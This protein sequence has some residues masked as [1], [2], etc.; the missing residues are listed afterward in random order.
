MNDNTIQSR[1]KELYPSQANQIGNYF[2]FAKLESYYSFLKDFNEVGGFFSKSDS[3]N[4]LD[5]HIIES[6]MHIYKIQQIFPVSHET[7]LADI[8]TGPG[9]PGYIFY[10]LKNPPQITLVDSQ[11]R[12]LGLLEKFHKETS[13]SKEVKFVYGRVEDIKEKFDLV[14]MRSTIKYPWSAEMIYGLLR[15]HSSFIPFLAKRNYDSNFEQMLLN[16]LG[17]N[18]EKEVDI[19]ELEFLGNRHIKV[20]K[21]VTE[22]KKGF[23]RKWETISK[24]IKRTTWEK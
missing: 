6:I 16:N 18:I 17:L 21:K 8:G 12:R 7:R 2:D 13:S 1:L 9:L 14:V 11:M 22:P 24:E 15:L 3:E 23:P 20:L 19:P 5:R 10:A 4:V